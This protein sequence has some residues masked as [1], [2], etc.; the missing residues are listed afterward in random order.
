VSCNLNDEVAILHLKN[1]LYFG[2]DEMGAYICDAMCEPT[3]V[4]DLRF[5]ERMARVLP[6]YRLTYPR[7][8][9]IFSQGAKH[10]YR[11]APT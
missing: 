2:P 11:S 10:I 5:A 9:E 3:K 8:L 1:S 4:S 7:D 6:V